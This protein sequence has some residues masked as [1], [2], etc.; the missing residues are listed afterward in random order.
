MDILITYIDS[1]EFID[2]FQ[3]VLCIIAVAL[4]VLALIFSKE[5]ARSL[6]LRVGLVGIGC[7]SAA[8]AFRGLCRVFSIDMVAYLEIGDVSLQ[9]AIATVLYILGII[10]V[11]LFALVCLYNLAKTAKLDRL[12]KK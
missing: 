7:I 1:F 2:V 5:V 6:I 8:L 9:Y 4:C 10:M 3:L 12:A 11:S